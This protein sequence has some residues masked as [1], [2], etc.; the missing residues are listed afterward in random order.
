M[1]TGEVIAFTRMPTLSF[2]QHNNPVTDFITKR[3]DPGFQTRRLVYQ[4]GRRVNSLIDMSMG[5]WG[6]LLA[7]HAQAYFDFMNA[8]QS[9]TLSALES[10]Q[11][12]L[13][14]LVRIQAAFALSP[15]RRNGFVYRREGVVSYAAFGNGIRRPT[16]IEEHAARQPI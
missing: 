11:N 8:A 12:S 3:N 7:R 6:N 14:E 13:S 9:L 4:H 1:S 15:S 10:H 16:F 5:F 2:G